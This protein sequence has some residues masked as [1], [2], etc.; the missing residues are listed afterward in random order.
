MF[1]LLGIAKFDTLLLFG[2]MDDTDTL[3]L[4]GIMDDTNGILILNALH[5]RK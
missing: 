1:L 4:S 5:V 3:L 2:I